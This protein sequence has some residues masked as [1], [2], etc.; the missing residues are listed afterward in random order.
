MVGVFMWVPAGKARGGRVMFVERHSTWEPTTVPYG[1][2]VY[3]EA[4]SY[5]YAA[6]FEYC[7]QY[8]TM[9]RLLPSE[10]IDAKTLGRCDVLVVKTPTERY[11]NDEVRAIVQFVREGGS[12]LLVGDHTNVFNMNT[13]LN[14]IARQFG[15][16]F[17]NDLLFR[18]G[19]PYKQ[20]YA[21]PLLAHPIVQHIP[22]MYFAVSCSIDPGRSAGG[23]AVRGRGLWSLPP[24]YHESNYH[25]KPSTVRGCSTVPGAS[26]GPRRLAG[27]GAGVADS[28]LFSNFCV[29]QPGK[30]ELLRGMLDWLNHHS[31]LDT[32]V[33]RGL[34]A[35]VCAAAAMVLVAIGVWCSPRPAGW[36]WPRRVW[37]AGAWLG[38]PSGP[39][40]RG[41]CPSQ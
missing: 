41:L 1:T 26:C 19:D 15:F 3:G 6:A 27:A 14:D 34:L 10:P 25:R 16:T 2:E 29:F 5:N 12:L 40:T 4:G 20:P 30:A 32:P 22:P 35:S 18:V 38:W 13:Y 23:T 37:P 31:H 39:Y 11:A 9:S 8:F 28:T 36:G 33:A 21:P 24:A 17:R 7:G